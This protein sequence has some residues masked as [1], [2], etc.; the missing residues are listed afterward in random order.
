[1]NTTDSPAWRR[2]LRAFTRTKSP[3]FDKQSFTKWNFGGILSPFFHPRISDKESNIFDD[4][5]VRDRTQPRLP[6]QRNRYSMGRKRREK[7]RTETNRGL[8]W[9]SLFRACSSC[10]SIFGSRYVMSMHD[11][12]GYG[13]FGRTSLM[14]PRTEGGSGGVNDESDER[15]KMSWQ[16]RKIFRVREFFSRVL[17]VVCCWCRTPVHNTTPLFVAFYF[18]HSST[19]LPS[20]LKTI[21]YEVCRVLIILKLSIS[22]W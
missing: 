8:Q 2:V 22:C 13:V 14:W 10:S 7:I 17:K 15:W 16:N 6:I 4:I 9:S 19:L 18:G 21:W 1:M 11:S 20:F 5:K 3:E 12:G